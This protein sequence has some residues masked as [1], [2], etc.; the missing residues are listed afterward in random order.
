MTLLAIEYL[1]MLYCTLCLVDYKSFFDVFGFQE[2]FLDIEK[3]QK[4]T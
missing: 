1:M 4:E 3:L 2:N